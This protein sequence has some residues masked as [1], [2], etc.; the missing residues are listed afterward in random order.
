MELTL[1]CSK[2]MYRCVVEL[3]T[4]IGTQATHKPYT[5]LNPQEHLQSDMLFRSK[6]CPWLLFCASALTFD[7]S[8]RNSFHLV[9]VSTIRYIQSA[10][11]LVWKAELSIINCIVA[12]GET[13]RFFPLSGFKIEETK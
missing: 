12:E 1:I 8:D 13:D 6:D 11:H 4:E 7:E 5:Y 2:S 9:N 3:Q 10:L